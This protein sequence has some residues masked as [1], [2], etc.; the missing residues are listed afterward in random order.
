[1]EQASSSTQGG[2]SRHHQFS[3]GSAMNLNPAEV[4]N[5]I[6][7]ALDALIQKYGVYCYPVFVWLS[8]G[9][10][11]WVLGGGLRRKRSQSNSTTITYGN[12]FTTRPPNRSPP[13][14]II[15]EIDPVQNDDNEVK[16]EP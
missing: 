14:T 3:G 8:P 10:I 7:N 13:P 2:N 9:A 12:I 16:D 15:T 1:L 11:A 5:P 4:L 6:F